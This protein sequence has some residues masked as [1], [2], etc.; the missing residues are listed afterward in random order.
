MQDLYEVVACELLVSRASFV[1]ASVFCWR[2]NAS[3][4]RS[5]V[6]RSVFR[7]RF[8]MTDSL[9]HHRFFFLSVPYQVSPLNRTPI[10]LSSAGCVRG[11]CSFLLSE[12][13][14][15]EIDQKIISY[16]SSFL[17]SNC[18]F[19]STQFLFRDCAYPLCSMCSWFFSL[20]LLLSSFLTVFFVVFCCC[21]WRW[22]SQVDLLPM[23]HSL[24]FS[25]DSLV[26]LYTFFTTYSHDPSFFLFFSLFVSSS[27]SHPSFW[28][29][30]QMK[31]SFWSLLAWLSRS[32]SIQP[33]GN[34]RERRGTKRNWQKRKEESSRS[35]WFFSTCT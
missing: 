7:F 6:T 11:G 9:H 32:I 4:F 8:S 12:E 19:C 33:R 34:Q 21:C 14:F 3:F 27:L 28:I 17:S 16:F 23:Y 18:C 2:S 1:F 26:S 29:T 20:Q 13:S 25:Y 35:V 10:N 30:K 24:P 22:F 5:I 15:S 31:T